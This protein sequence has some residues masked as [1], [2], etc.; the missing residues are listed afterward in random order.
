M[1]EIFR[2]LNPFNHIVFIL[3]YLA[4]Q[5]LTHKPKLTEQK[6]LINALELAKE[7]V[8]EDLNHLERRNAL[9]TAE[10]ELPGETRNHSPVGP[11]Q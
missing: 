2:R 5:T 9:A 8:L 11:S 6:R 3:L 7:A 4:V 10:G 1:L